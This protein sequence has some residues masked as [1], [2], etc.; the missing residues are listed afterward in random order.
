MAIRHGKVCY[1]QLPAVDVERSAEF[2]SAVFGWGLRRR[3]DGSLAFDDTALDNSDGTLGVSGTW[4]TDRPPS[5]VPGV[6]IWIMVDDV[7]ATL[8]AIVAAGGEV[9]DPISGEAP[10]FT[11]TFRDP[12]GN[13]LGVGQQ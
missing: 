7:A 8:D 10:E 12:A 11:A 5:T 13:V 3:G 9:V 2:Y 4:V 6:L 1:L